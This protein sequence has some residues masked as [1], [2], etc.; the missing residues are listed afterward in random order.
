MD[1]T[2]DAHR[3]TPMFDLAGLETSA[4]VV[5][6]HDGDT[7][8]AVFPFAGRLRQFIVRTLHVDSPEMNKPEQHAAAVT[9]RNRVL[10]LLSPAAAFAANA[11]YKVREIEDALERHPAIVTLRCGAFDKYGRVLASVVTERGED[12]AAVLRQEGLVH[13]YEG[14]T[15]EAWG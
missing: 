14:G 10:Q 12:V 2:R 4:R 5:S 11:E 9:A 8:R 15:K 6:A 7:L 1:L 13:D 3:S